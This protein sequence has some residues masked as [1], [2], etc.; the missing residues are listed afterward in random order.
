MQP[1]ACG[2]PPTHI[3]AAG[4]LIRDCGRTTAHSGKESSHARKDNRILPEPVGAFCRQSIFMTFD[5]PR[6]QYV[7][8]PG[9]FSACTHE[10]QRRDSLLTGGG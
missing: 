3:S 9:S 10:L 8:L 1:L 7:P 2:A 4:L 6:I 5:F